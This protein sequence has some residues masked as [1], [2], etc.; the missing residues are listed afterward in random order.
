V[1]MLSLKN[2]AAVPRRQG[3]GEV[4]PVRVAVGA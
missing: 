2:N 3:R 1:I 4:E